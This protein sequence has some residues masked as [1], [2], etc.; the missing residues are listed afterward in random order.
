[1]T[2]KMKDSGVEWIG[3]IPEDWHI[4]RL[5]FLCEIKTG[6]KDTINAK[7]DGIYPFYVRS[8]KIE[9]IDS[10]TFEGEAI[11][12]AGDGVGAGKVFHYAKGK[13]DYHQ[14]VYNL[15]GFKDI[16]AKYLF[17]Y[18]REN[19]Y[20]E[21]EK[22]NAKSTVD[23]I[24]LPMLLNFPIAFSERAE[25]RIVDYLDNKCSRIDEFIAREKQLV[26]KLKDYKQSMIT[27]AVT[28]GLNPDVKLKASGVEWIGDIPKHWLVCKLGKLLD[29]I[30]DGTHSSYNRVGTGEF[31][32][33]AKNVYND[34]LRITENES[35]ISKVDYEDII[36]CG[37][38]DYGDVLLTTIG[39][40]IGRALAYVF[41][42]VYAFQRSVIFLRPNKGKLNYQF[43][44]YLLL[45]EPLQIQM[46]LG[47]SASAQDGIYSANIKKYDVSVPP[48]IEQQQIADYLDKKC[49][50]IE[51]TIDLKEKLIEKLVAYKKS[52]IYECVTG[53]RT[54]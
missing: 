24:R 54:V 27:E 49:V 28:K 51:S 4:K 9:K 32:L 34:G 35:M 17:Y 40:S 31:L 12:M 8:P 38:P 18:L 20:K 22:S 45:S 5:R 47:S 36:K 3:E 53:K 19:F 26:E 43:L 30:K 39:A 37:Y 33:S 7:D 10:F 50:A 23:S 13:F 6:N 11:L 42:E 14:R 44:V 29:G 48:I 15:H 21:I 25:C 16:K 46:K 41:N 52:L 2:R 1:M